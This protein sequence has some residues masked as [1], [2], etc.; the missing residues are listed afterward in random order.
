MV[1]Y[2]LT[3][4]EIDSV[5]GGGKKRGGRRP[6]GCNVEAGATVVRVNQHQKAKIKISSAKS[7]DAD[8]IN[9]SQTQIVTIGDIG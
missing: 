1:F 2:K 3:A 7:A 5:G 4:V 6:P 8:R 9:A